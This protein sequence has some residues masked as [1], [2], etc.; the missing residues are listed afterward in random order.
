MKKFAAFLLSLL[1]VFGLVSTQPAFADNRLI[2]WA[3][4]SSPDP[5][6]ALRCG[7]DGWGNVYVTL[8]LF[9]NPNKIFFRDRIDTVEAAVYVVPNGGLAF[10]KKHPDSP[11]YYRDTMNLR[12]PPYVAFL[13]SMVDK[14]DIRHVMTLNGYKL[15]Q[16]RSNL[17]Q[18][19]LNTPFQTPSVDCPGVFGDKVPGGIF[20]PKI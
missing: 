15:L 13:A 10:F 1:I 14:R 5:Q 19:V 8:Q 7:R 17:A 11:T 3:D 16:A 2:W 6:G 4:Y 18:G 20:I 9:Y 12:L